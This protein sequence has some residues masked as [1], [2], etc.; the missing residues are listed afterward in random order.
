MSAV[1]LL[2][3]GGRVVTG[4]GVVDADV[5]IDGERIAALTGGETRPSARE[6][7]DARGML[8]LPGLIDTHTHHREPGFTHKEDITTATRAAAAGGVTTSVGMPNVEPPTNTLERYRAVLDTYERKSL[9]DFNHNPAPTVLDEIPRLARAGALGFKVWM[10]ADTKR[11]YPHMPGTAVHDHGALLEIAEAV[12]AT[13][14]PLMVHPHDQ[15]LM[16]AIERRFW[17]RGETD[18]RAYAR[19]Y[20]SY[21]GMTW[22]GAVAWLIR[23]SE[24]TGVRL[25][26]LHVKTRRMAELVRQAKARGQRVT[27]ELNPIAVF[28]C[29]EWAN[30]E[31]LGPYALSTWTGEGQAEHL[32]RAL[33]DGTIDVVGTDHAPHTRDEK[34]IGW[35][36]MW[37]AAGGAPAIQDYLSLFLTAVADG[38]I[39]LE[40]VVELTST[41]PAK[42]FGLQPKK[43]EIRVG[44]DADLVVVDPERE[45]VISDDDALSKCGWT[46]FAGLRVRGAPLHTLVRGRFVLREGRVVGEPG[47]GRLAAPPDAVPERVA[48]PA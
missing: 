13:G 1:D 42:V 14:R 17:S 47:W 26:V 40:R 35:I 44:A 31:R 22:D 24:A 12:A 45:R 19:A 34:E 37:K 41:R 8:V 4:A 5:A 23:L 38:R 20:A 39:T 46:P 43:G 27:S 18:H 10:I 33:N 25:H 32:W 48:T 15:G 21:E 29:D 16:S 11:P 2:L 6:T 3:A 7:V 9:V 36:D 28:L 30:V